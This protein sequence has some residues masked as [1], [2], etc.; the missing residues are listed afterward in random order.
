MLPSGLEQ[1][2]RLAIAGATLFAMS[3]PPID[4]GTILI[5]KGKITEVGNN[6]AVPEGYRSSMQRDSLS[7]RGWS[8]PVPMSE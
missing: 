3:G 8:R 2:E 1:T 6:I 4:D 7:C 5:D